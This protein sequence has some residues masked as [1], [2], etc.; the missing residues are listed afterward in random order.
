MALIKIFSGHNGSLE[1]LPPV[2]FSAAIGLSPLGILI[3]L[4]LTNK[5]TFT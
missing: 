1:S 4:E 2:K 5:S 3:A